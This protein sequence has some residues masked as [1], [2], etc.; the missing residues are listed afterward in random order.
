MTP[1]LWFSCGVVVILWYGLMGLRRVEMYDFLYVCINSSSYHYTKGFSY[2]GFWDI[3]RYLYGFVV[4][5]WEKNTERMNWNHT[6]Y[7][8]F[9]SFFISFSQSK[10]QKS[11]HHSFFS[12]Q[13]KKSLAFF[14]SA[15][16][17][18]VAV[19]DCGMRVRQPAFAADFEAA[20]HAAQLL[21]LVGRQSPAVEVKVCFYAGF[22][23]WFGYDACA[24]L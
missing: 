17:L 9:I 14:F 10:Q 3:Y 5:S 8:T 12:R 24:A 21:Y 2:F 1:L 18:V 13:R 11:N 15:L 22:G 6:T 20:F 23:D 4:K 7:H 16:S 19:E